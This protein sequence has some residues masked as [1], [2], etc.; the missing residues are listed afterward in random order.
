MDGSKN[1]I[2]PFLGITGSSV[3]SYLS[4]NSCQ[5]NSLHFFIYEKQRLQEL[6]VSF[7]FGILEPSVH[8]Q[9]IHLLE[10][11]CKNSQSAFEVV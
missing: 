11:N 1:P 5:Y 10:W 2:I 8:N 6:A 9:T 4:S 7:N 3:P